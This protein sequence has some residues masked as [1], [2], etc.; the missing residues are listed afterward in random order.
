MIPDEDLLKAI[1]RIA[2]TEDGH[3]LYMWLQRILFG[4]SLT[5]EFGTLARFEGQRILALQ[6]ME[7]MRDGLTATGTDFTRP[8]VIG[9][10]EQPAAEPRTA[11]EWIERNDPEYAA[12]Q[13]RS[14]RS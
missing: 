11:R 7:L 6:L 5:S 12:V 2:R 3:F 10:R 4:I 13:R 9:K 1:D 14:R 8:V